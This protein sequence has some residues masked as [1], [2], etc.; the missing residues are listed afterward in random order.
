MVKKL[1]LHERISKTI[2]IL[3]VWEEKVSLIVLP[4]VKTIS[5]V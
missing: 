5:M 3:T 1:V 4:I 2:L